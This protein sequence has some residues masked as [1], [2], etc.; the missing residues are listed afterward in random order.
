MFS[1]LRRLSRK[2]EEKVFP[3][4]IAP[5]DQQMQK[6]YAK[7]VQYNMKIIIKG[8][9]N[10][11]KSALLHRLTGCEFKEEYIPTHEIQVANVNWNYR[12][13]EDIV[14]VEVWDIVDKSQKRKNPSDGLKIQNETANPADSM[15]LDA[16]FINVYKGTHGVIIILD[17]TKAWTWQYTQRELDKIPAHIAVLILANFQD[18]GEHKVVQTEEIISFIEHY[19]RPSGSAEIYFCECSV[20]EG[21]GLSFIYK[22]LNMPF[23]ILQRETLLRQL[24]ANTLEIEESRETLSIDSSSPEQCYEKFKLLQ[25]APETM[26]S[27]H[28]SSYDLKIVNENEGNEG[29]KD[30]LVTIKAQQ[31]LN[32]NPIKQLPVAQVT[33]PALNLNSVKQLPVAQATPPVES[34]KPITDKNNAETLKP[35]R[36]QLYK[37]KFFGGDVETKDMF[38]NQQEVNNVDE[39]VPDQLDSEFLNTST[40]I[41]TAPSNR[42]EN[43]LMSNSISDDDDICDGKPTIASYEDLESDHNDVSFE[44]SESE[45][46]FDELSDSERPVIKTPEHSMFQVKPSKSS[47]TNVNNDIIKHNG[48]NKYNDTKKNDTSEY[49]CANKHNDNKKYDSSDC[50]DTKK[51]SDNNKHVSKCENKKS[52]SNEL[53]IQ[54]DDDSTN[55]SLNLQSNCLQSNQSNISSE[56]ENN[57]YEIASVVEEDWMQ[58]KSADESDTKDEKEKNKKNNEKIKNTINDSKKNS[59]VVEKK[60]SINF[61]VDELEIFMQ[62]QLQKTPSKDVST[63]E[64][65]VKEKKKKKKTSLTQGNETAENV[66]QKKKLK[67]TDLQN[68]VTANSSDLS[69]SK[70]V[71][72]QN[73][74]K[75]IKSSDEKKKKTKS[76]TKQTEDTLDNFFAS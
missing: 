67:A 9:R 40:V 50:N 10:T 1:A 38:K 58:D 43:Y 65:K 21:F 17:I 36:F 5:V 44:K 68:Q 29:N 18:M 48:T 59:A 71:K 39:F 33:P 74:T 3:S 28:V 13:A 72:N 8:D 60:T 53:D 55:K 56:E 51:Y 63:D 37:S 22:F 24:E 34:T 76:K 49:N 27:K 14:K 23:L 45:E 4:G 11:G 19:E 32:L 16:E 46:E 31:A 62:N 66:K 57:V 52:S 30:D 54:S 2:P 20:K 64:I 41:A 70:E 12:G 42:K 47:D 26:G 73:A 25:K 6:K 75:H 61:D 7:G 35:S 15:V 69:K